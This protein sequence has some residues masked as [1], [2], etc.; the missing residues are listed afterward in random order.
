[1]PKLSSIQKADE[2]AEVR[3]P[4]EGSDEDANLVV[5]PNRITGKRRR[6]FAALED[7]DDDDLPE[8]ETVSDRYAEL[9]FDIIKSWDITDETGT[10]LPFTADTVDL[11][12]VKTT[13]RLF[14]EIGEQTNPNAKKT[15]KRSRGR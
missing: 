7:L 13:I 4:F 14:E 3:I 1:M 2:T 10:P 8:G 15:S 12:S 6:A 5:F 9:F 11:L